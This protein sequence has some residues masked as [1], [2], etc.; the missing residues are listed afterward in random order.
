MTL[1]RPSGQRM[2]AAD[3]RAHAQSAHFLQRDLADVGD[4][5][6]GDGEVARRLLVAALVDAQRVRHRPRDR[7][8]STA[9]MTKEP[10]S[11]VKA[12]SST[13][14]STPPLMALTRAPSMR[15]VGQAV[16]D[17]AEHALGDE[18]DEVEV[19]VLA[20]LA[21]GQGHRDAL[22]MVVVDGGLD[23]VVARVDADERV[24]AVGVGPVRL[25]GAREDGVVVRVVELHGGIE[26]RVAAGVGEDVSG[27]ALELVSG[28][29]D[30]L[31]AR[32]RPLDHDD[33]ALVVGVAVL[34]GGHRVGAGGEPAEHVGAV[35]G[36][37]GLPDRG[38]VLGDLHR[39]RLD[40]LPTRRV[41]D[42]AAHA[43]RL[44]LA[45]PSARGARSRP[46]R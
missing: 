8:L 35:G 45:R 28:E 21:A 19:D 5:P 43:R 23:A 3:L 16:D 31:A 17:P 33:R 42:L 34:A 10:S 46:G 30:V 1:G 38:A 2:Q 44:V 26:D 36:G 37:T 9:F 11:A 25:D 22:G 20:Q 6:P 40:R 4:P 15:V 18:L 24:G 39:R 13:Q 12:T 14:P 32:H 7:R 29:R 41:E 27:D